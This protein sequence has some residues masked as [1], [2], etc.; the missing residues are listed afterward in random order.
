MYP[1]AE[2]T[3]I[4]LR[5]A[6]VRRDITRLRGQCAAAAVRVARPLV[7]LDRVVAFAR[8]LSPLLLIAAVPAGLVAQRLIFPRFKI[9]GLVLRWA[10]PV[11][12]AVRGLRTPFQ[13]KSV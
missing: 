12:A 10:P 8:R 3:V 13:S 2:L 7:W 11:I 6:A 1:H 9:L 4:A 5:K